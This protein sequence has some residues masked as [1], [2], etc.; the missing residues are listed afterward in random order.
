ME[1]ADPMALLLALFALPLALLAFRRRR[2]AYG[3]PSTRALATLRPTMR[4]RLARLIPGM[5]IAAVVLLAVAL[6]RPRVG[7]AT[8][9]VPAEGV[10][11]ALAIDVSSSMSTSNF[12]SG[13]SRLEVTKQVIRDF[14][15]GRENDRIGV[16]VF[17]RDALP[18]SPPSLD[19]AALDTIVSQV[20]SGIL[21]DG[22]GI[23]VGLAEALNMLRESSATSRVVI[24]LT[25]GEHNAPSI[26]P[27]EAADLAEALHIRVY[28]IGV[29][30]SDDVRGSGGVDEKL[31][32]D[33]ASR[34]GGEYFAADNPKTLAAVYDEI[35]K[36]ETSRVGRERFERFSEFEPW[37]AG[38]AAALFVL[39]LLLAATWLR[40]APA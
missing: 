15:K 8:A 28:T 1:F 13:K 25:D 7:E 38:G 24:L 37:F 39:E 16:V 12:G 40:R 32:R 35:G 29:I 22:T 21:P 34:T 27:R 20:D 36:L 4:V 2:A 3:V 17:Q 19:Y 31:L 5:R 14:I 26:S 10:D 23:G 11:I 9:V 6:A 33:I 30:R 18:L